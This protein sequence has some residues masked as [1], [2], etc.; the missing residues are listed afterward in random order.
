MC[1]PAVG[2]RGREPAFGPAMSAAACARLVRAAR[3]CAK[4]RGRACRLQPC[5][6]STPAEALG[7]RDCAIARLRVRDCE[8]ASAI[9]RAVAQLRG[10]TARLR[11]KPICRCAV[12]KPAGATADAR[13]KNT[14]TYARARTHA[15]RPTCAHTQS[16]HSTGVE[17]R[18]TRECGCAMRRGSN[19]SRINI[20][21][22]GRRI[23]STTRF[24]PLMHRAHTHRVRRS[25]VEAA[26]SRR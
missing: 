22:R 17:R 26:I 14:Q 8:C 1:Y 10:R 23:V 24:Q 20:P 5:A 3:L 9:A 6:P 18:T 4:V 15:H 21:A 13:S 19:C 2:R 11:R 7:T 16:R 25:R 12:E